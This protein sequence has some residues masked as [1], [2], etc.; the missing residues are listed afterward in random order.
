M[1]KKL[2][3]VLLLFILGFFIISQ[4]N[5]KIILS[6]I[7][8]FL[9]GMHFMEDGFKQFSGGILEE[10]LEKFTSN[11]YKSL[12]TGFISTSIVQSSSLISV[13]I[14]SFLSVGLISLT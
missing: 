10:I 11:K 9:I 1:A 8:I 5:I 3:I 4:E 2:F 12:L 6:G 13:I 7:A 14:I